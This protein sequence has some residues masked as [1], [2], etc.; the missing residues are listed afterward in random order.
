MLIPFS[1][2]PFIDLEWL[3]THIHMRTKLNL[4]PCRWFYHKS[5]CLCWLQIIRFILVS[6]Q[7]ETLNGI[8][9]C[10]RTAGSTTSICSRLWYCAFE[11]YVHVHDEWRRRCQRRRPR[12]RSKVKSRKWNIS[13]LRKGIRLGAVHCL[14]KIPMELI[15][16]CQGY[17]IVS[18]LILIANNIKKLMY[19]IRDFLDLST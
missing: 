2:S 18:L 13:T 5:C 10:A 17:E 1:S 4:S 8:L 7:S 16:S 11:I 19:A 9:L 12:Q 15:C 3:S 14:L 6:M